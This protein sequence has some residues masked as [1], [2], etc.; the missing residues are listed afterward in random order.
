MGELVTVTLFIP[1]FV[2]LLAPQVAIAMMRVLERLG[3]TVDYPES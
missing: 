1:C 3:H 2:D